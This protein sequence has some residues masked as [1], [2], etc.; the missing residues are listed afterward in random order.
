MY[1]KF[2]G[3]TSYD[4][5]YP[6]ELLAEQN[7][8]GYVLLYDMVAILLAYDLHEDPLNNTCFPSIFILYC[9]Q[10]NLSFKI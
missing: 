9:T 3:V 7:I 4:N 2:Q 1:L 5:D 6:C 10:K 8:V